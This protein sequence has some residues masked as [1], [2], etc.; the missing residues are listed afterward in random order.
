RIWYQPEEEDV[1]CV[2]TWAV[3]F[4]GLVPIGLSLPH[5]R[6]CFEKNSII[7]KLHRYYYTAPGSYHLENSENPYRALLQN[8]F[9]LPLSENKRSYTVP[10]L[11]RLHSTKLAHRQ[12]QKRCQE[13][14]ETLVQNGI[15][16]SSRSS[17]LAMEYI[18]IKIKV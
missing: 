17:Q 3:Y 10:S 9:E 4:S 12:Q 14:Q 13:L 6:L 18:K 15:T 5:N 11:T 2:S 7:F 8:G 1:K 16:H